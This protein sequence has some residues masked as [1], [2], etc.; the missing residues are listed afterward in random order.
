MKFYTEKGATSQSS[1]R[2]W[3]DNCKY[4]VGKVIISYWKNK[5][6]HKNGN[7]I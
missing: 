6:L 2:E 4:K 5:K 1:C 3:K 7:V